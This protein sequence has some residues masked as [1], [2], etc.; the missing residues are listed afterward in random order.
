LHDKRLVLAAYRSSL[1]T[2]NEGAVVTQDATTN[3]FTA[4]VTAALAR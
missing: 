3:A 4:A 1:V 2:V